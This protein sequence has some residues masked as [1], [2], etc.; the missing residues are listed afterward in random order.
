MAEN[1]RCPNCDTRLVKDGDLAQGMD[2]NGMS[3]PFM[4]CPRCDQALG[5][6]DDGQIVPVVLIPS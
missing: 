4:A 2:E 1:W 5:L 6:R 3:L